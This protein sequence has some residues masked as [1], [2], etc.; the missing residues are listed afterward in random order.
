MHTE[1]F[2]DVAASRLELRSWTHRQ[3]GFCYQHKQSSPADATAGEGGSYL[4]ERLHDWGKSSRRSASVGPRR[5]E[6]KL[7]TLSPL[8]TPD[9]WHARPPAA[10]SGQGETEESRHDGKAQR[11]RRRR[12]RDNGDTKGWGWQPAAA[13]RVWTS[14]KDWALNLD[15][16]V[17]R[18]GGVRALWHLN[19]GRGHRQTLHG[20]KLD[21]C[22]FIGRCWQPQVAKQIRN[23]CQ[24]HKH[25]LTTENKTSGVPVHTVRDSTVMIGCWKTFIL[26]YIHFN[27]IN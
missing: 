19:R 18:G 26:K 9:I 17:V 21:K 11:K 6:K 15:W 2:S 10:P 24:R 25:P 27:D 14:G 5:L 16:G 12:R 7:W 13:S 8:T 4:G 3:T 23:H 1:C 20:F 22:L